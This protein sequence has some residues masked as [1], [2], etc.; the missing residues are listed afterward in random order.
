MEVLFEAS[1]LSLLTTPIPIDALGMMNVDEPGLLVLD[2][3][4]AETMLLLKP[5]DM[6][7]LIAQLTTGALPIVP[8]DDVDLHPD[9]KPQYNHD[10]RYHGSNTGYYSP[11]GSGYTGSGS[12]SA[13]GGQ[14]T[15]FNQTGDPAPEDIL[16]I[17]AGCP[18]E[19][20]AAQDALETLYGT[21]RTARDLIDRAIA[22]GI[23]LRLIDIDYSGFGVRDEFSGTTILW[24]PFSY[25]F[26]KNSD[27]TEYNISPLMLLAHELVHAG[28]AGNPA[29]QGFDSEPSVIPI[30][31]QIAREVNAATGLNFNTTRDRHGGEY[32]QTN[33]IKSTVF[34]ITEPGCP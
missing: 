12:G 16:R 27:G 3:P 1:V 24:D 19:F 2:V 17:E 31:N 22:L 6:D 23:N 29:F 33:S 20:A 8:I 11:E 9:L 21:S 25:V 13:G 32:R 26:G 7:V 5:D 28:N 15:S 34:S 18:V 14:D 4:A 30:A 10:G